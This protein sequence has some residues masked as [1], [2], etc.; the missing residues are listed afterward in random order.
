MVRICPNNY[1]EQNGIKINST[2]RNPYTNSTITK[3]E[4]G[5]ALSHYNAWKKQL[6]KEGVRYPIIMEDDIQFTADFIKVL[7][8]LVNKNL[9][10][11]LI[12]LLQNY[13][14]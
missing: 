1:F 8:D 6:N 2:F 12:Y 13:W 5:C 3:G 10:F 7:N 14:Y 9:E 11:D 4:I